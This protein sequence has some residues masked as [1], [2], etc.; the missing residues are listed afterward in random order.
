MRIQSLWPA[1]RR[2]WNA[3]RSG[4]K[5]PLILVA[6]VGGLFGLWFL[7]EW[8]IDPANGGE[9]REVITLMAQIVGG[10]IVLVGVAVA[11]RR[12]TI[13]EQTLQVTEQG[14]ITE[15]YTR[16]IEQ[17]GHERREV[18]LGAI[19]A[20]ERISKD[21]ERDY[22]TVMEVL[23]AYVRDRSPTD[24]PKPEP[25]AEVKRF[26]T[27]IQAALTVIGRREGV[28]TGTIDLGGAYLP[29]ASLADANL[30][31]AYLRKANLHGGNL[32]ETELQGADLGGANLQSA[33]LSGANLQ[34]ALLFD[35]SLQ[36]AFL[37][38]ANLQGGNLIGANLQGAAL[39]GASLQG[40]F[41]MDA[42]LQGALFSDVNLQE[43]D[44]SRAN[45]QGA[46]LSRA[47][48][49]TPE[50]IADAEVDEAT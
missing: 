49:L 37:F 6:A 30:Q 42:N 39:G 31:G 43:A 17:L 15:R 26:P 22:W 4:A 40:A 27:D 16:A 12:M 47:R 23:S 20:L 9:K 45:L 50:Q 46:D 29:G 36:G 10:S 28:D 38:D 41:L 2:T 35:A 8:Q 18:R 34:S 25:E 32:A 1:V 13:T 24:V 19:Y 33:V 3:L 14:Q 21:S 48:N 5:W 11:W 7:L 44:L